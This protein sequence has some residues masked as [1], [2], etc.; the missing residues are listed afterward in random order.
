M[1]HAGRWAA[2]LCCAAATLYGA[3]WRQ[4]FDG[5][6]YA[7]AMPADKAWALSDQ[8]ESTFADGVRGRALD[9]RDRKSV[10]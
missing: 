3:E 8:L 9:L 4:S 6:P 1:N 10:V 5:E 2:A 7:C